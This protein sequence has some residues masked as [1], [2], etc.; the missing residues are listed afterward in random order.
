V[1]QLDLEVSTEDMDE[2]ICADERGGG[3]GSWYKL[4]RPGRPEGGPGP[5]NV[6]YVFVFLGTVIIC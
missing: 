5:Y 6:A 4:Q 1:K 3:G 2:V